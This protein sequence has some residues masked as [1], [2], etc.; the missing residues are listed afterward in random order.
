MLLCNAKEIKY[1]IGTQ[2]TLVMCSFIYHILFSHVMFQRR[3]SH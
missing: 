2:Q 3:S 1:L